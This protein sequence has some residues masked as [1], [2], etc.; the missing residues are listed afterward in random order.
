MSCKNQDYS[1]LEL[2]ISD[3]ASCDST[4]QII[5]DHTFDFP[6]PVILINHQPAGIGANW[7]NCIKHAKGKYIKF[8]FQDDLLEPDCISELVSLLESQPN[9]AIAACKRNILFDKMNFESQSW[10]S[11]Y[12]DLQGLL[13]EDILGEYK[14][15]KKDFNYTFFYVGPR[16]KIGEPSTVLL[17]KKYLS[18]VG[19]FRTDLKQDLDF[20]Y[21]W[22]LMDK[23]TILISSKK[24]ASFRIHSN[25]ATNKNKNSSTRDY[26]IIMSLILSKYIWKMPFK[27]SKKVLMK[28]FSWLR[29]TLMNKVFRINK[30]KFLYDGRRS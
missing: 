6:F 26:L 10:L 12:G 23:Y 21:W 28:E 8:L 5:R 14:L 22:R 15:T 4:I 16:N 27:E 25:Q 2:V 11:K 3:D 29:K 19:E 30:N 13:K 1:N 20:E 24:L 18:S 7:N 9:V 17:N